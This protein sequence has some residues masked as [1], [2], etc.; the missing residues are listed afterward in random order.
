MSVLQIKLDG[1]EA[2]LFGIKATNNIEAHDY[3]LQATAKQ[4]KYTEKNTFE[5]IALYNKAL[6]LDPNY[7]AAQAWLARSVALSWSQ[8]WN[9]DPAI[10]DLA[11]S[12]AE[13]AEELEPQF[14]YAI[15]I[16]GWTQLWR[17]NRDESIAECRRAIAI[18]PNNA[19]AQLFLSIILAEASLG[20]V[21]LYYIEKSKRFTPTSSPLHEMA[22]GNCYFVLKDYPKAIAA[23][24]L[25]CTMNP[26]FIP[27][28]LLAMV[29]YEQLGMEDKVSKKFEILYRITG[30]SKNQPAITLWTDNALTKQHEEI[31]KK[32]FHVILES[33]NQNR[34][35]ESPMDIGLQGMFF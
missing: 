35:S 13:R 18:D 30:D 2:S 33:L 23:Y 24:E 28:Q 32:L 26:N 5:A 8:K 15:S 21:A 3:L 1:I 27:C 19:E 10:L 29:A 31:W 20:E 9:H 12:H 25:S 7:A 22:Q 16:L 4:R 11:L 17:N 14:P 34:C 6:T